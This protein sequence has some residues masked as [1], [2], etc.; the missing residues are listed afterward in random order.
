M[1]YN[2]ENTSSTYYRDRVEN[3]T[4]RRVKR[5]FKNVSLDFGANF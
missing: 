1:A 4:A 3:D 2:W 5:N